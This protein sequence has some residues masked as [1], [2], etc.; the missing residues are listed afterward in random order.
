MPGQEEGIH[1]QLAALSFTITST[2]LKDLI[3]RQ[4]VYL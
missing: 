3:L 2:Y 4:I 1:S